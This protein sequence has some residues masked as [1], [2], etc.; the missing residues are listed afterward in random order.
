MLVS[1]SI[2]YNN[3]SHINVSHSNV[4]HNVS[5]NS[6]SYNNVLILEFVVHWGLRVQFVALAE[7]S[8]IVTFGFALLCGTIYRPIVEYCCLGC[9]FLLPVSQ[10]VPP[11]YCD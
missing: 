2:S 10:F 3:V 9:S 1:Y 4:S 7:S 5:Y 6:V 11:N 8:Y